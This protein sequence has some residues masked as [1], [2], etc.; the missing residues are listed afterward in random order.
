V[1]VYLIHFRKRKG[2]VRQTQFFQVL[3]HPATPQLHQ[4]AQAPVLRGMSTQPMATV[5]PAA[6]VQEPGTFFP[7]LSMQESM[8]NSITDGNFIDAK[9]F[10]YSRRSHEPGRVGTPEVLFVNTHVLATA[11]SYFRFSTSSLLSEDPLSPFP[12]CLIA[13]KVSRPV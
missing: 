1:N 6:P 11:C 5:R 9:L 13:L 3:P 12:Q 4:P 10:A 8:W 7:P 2:Q